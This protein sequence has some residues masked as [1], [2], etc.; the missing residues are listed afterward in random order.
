[1]RRNIVQQ[2]PTTLM[3]SLPIKWVR[4]YGL[5]KGEQVNVEE[6]GR[7]LTIST[8]E[9]TERT[10]TE[11]DLLNEDYTYIWRMISTAYVSGYDEIKINFDKL[12]ILKIVQKIVVEYFVGFEIVEQ[13]KDY[14]IIKNVSGNRIDEFDAILKR[15]FLTLIQTSE[16]FRDYLEKGEDPSLILDLEKINNRQTY[17]LKRLLI[18]EGFKVPEKTNFVFTLNFLLEQIL[19]EYKFAV[20]YINDEK[21]VK[22]TKKIV[23]H[24][25]KLHKEIKDVYQLYYNYDDE[26]IEKILVNGLK[27]NTETGENLVLFK[28]DARLAHS[29][30][31]ITEKIRYIA[32]QIVGI[33]N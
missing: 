14:C 6:R 25:D 9:E 21:S 29:I 31:N 32:N 17:L 22:V 19:N 13:K 11:I 1:M 4:K 30:T 20:W 28:D 16:I 12:E 3:V 24:Y 10:K 18:R 7:E 33:N 8:E 2:G 15:I 23:E 5:K 26:L 27:T